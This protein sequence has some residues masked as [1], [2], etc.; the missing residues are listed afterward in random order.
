MTTPAL[1]LSGVCAQALACL[2]IAAPA[3]AQPQQ[4]GENLAAPQ[5][6]QAVARLRP[7]FDD[8]DVAWDTWPYDGNYNPGATLSTALDPRPGCHPRRHG[9]AEP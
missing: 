5:I 8:I 7:A 2:A 6:A 3:A 9:R 4:C 1:A